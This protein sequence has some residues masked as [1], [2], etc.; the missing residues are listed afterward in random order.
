MATERVEDAA[1]EVPAFVGAALGGAGLRSSVASYKAGSQPLLELAQGLEQ[2][3]TFEA[4]T[5][6]SRTS[7]GFDGKMGFLMG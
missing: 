5:A 3:R 4:K 6:L 1:P 2:E 7:S